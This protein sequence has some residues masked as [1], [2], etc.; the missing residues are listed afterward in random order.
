MKKLLFVVATSISLLVASCSQEKQTGLIWSDEFNGNEL[1]QS[2]W[3][4]IVGNG[5]PQLCGFGNNELQYY[6]DNPKNLSVENGILTISATQD[7]IGENGFQSAKLV[8]QG[9]ASWK[10][11]RF[12]V[13]A[14]IP[15][16]KGNWP[17]IWMLPEK[18]KYGGWPRSGEIDIMEHVGYNPNMVYGTVHTESFNHMKQTEDNDSLSVA[19]LYEDFHVFAIEWSE[20][21][22]DWYI[23]EK[24]YHTFDN[25]GNHNSD[26]WPFDQPFYMILN[27]A[28]GGSWGGKYGIANDIFPNRMEIDYVRVYALD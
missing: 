7:S 20:D 10:Y 6:T 18:N 2:K 27:V 25:R 19:S 1:D 14:K 5:C 16:G 28:V 15:G 24:K 26:E 22:I 23:D 8:T 9:L 21:K 11:G 12:E 13:R 3:K 17:A 4:T